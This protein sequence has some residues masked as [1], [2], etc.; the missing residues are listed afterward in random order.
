[1]ACEVPFDL[2]QTAV[3]QFV[4]ELREIDRDAVER[5]AI[6]PVQLE[7]GDDFERDAEALGDESGRNDGRTALSKAVGCQKDWSTVNT[8][9]VEQA[10]Y[11]LTVA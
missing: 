11:V 8:S 4:I 3:L 10:F 1:M 9:L 7:H 6:G 2:P 5:C